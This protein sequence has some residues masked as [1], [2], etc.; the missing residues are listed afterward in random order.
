MNAVGIEE[1]E[2]A[3]SMSRWSCNGIL[4]HSV[5]SINWMGVF[6]EWELCV[7]VENLES[8]SHSIYAF[9]LI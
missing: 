4:K 8:R 6:L 2:G 9:R 5:N 7:Q 1:V 3:F